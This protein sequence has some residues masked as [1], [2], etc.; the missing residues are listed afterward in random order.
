MF[1]KNN[2]M[3]KLWKNSKSFSTPFVSNEMEFVSKIG[4]NNIHELLFQMGKDPHA[5][6]DDK[7]RLYINGTRKKR[8]YEKKFLESVPKLCANLTVWLNNYFLEN[9]FLIF[10]NYSTS[11]SKK[12]SVLFANLAKPVIDLYPPGS[13][14]LETHLIIGRYQTTP[15]GVHVDD[16]NDR[17]IH[18]NLSNTPKHLHL[19]EIEKFFELTGSYEF[20]EHMDSIKKH[21]TTYTMQKGDAF[22]LPA[23]YYHV[24]ESPELSI[25]AAISLTKLSKGDIL[26]RVLTV[27]S[28]DIKAGFSTDKEPNNFEPNCAIDAL[29]K[30]PFLQENSLF[31]NVFRAAL[32][33]Y[34]ARVKS[35][36]YFVEKPQ[37]KTTLNL[38]AI[39]EEDMQFKKTSPFNIQFVE[40]D[41]RITL[42]S[43]GYQ[44]EC[45]AHHEV[46]RI[47]GKIR[48]TSEFYVS[49]L[50]KI[51]NNIRPKFV[52][53]IVNWLYCTGSLEVL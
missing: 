11:W 37:I 49:D 5:Y 6:H 14:S 45:N 35:N 43:R 20:I 27:V 7:I 23:S 36:M 40:N 10:V 46:L 47:I 8:F 39:L 18:F 16:P 19:W 25:V 41:G 29:R 4:L 38:D 48:E 42:Y 50:L 15:F 34:N 24:G 13:L 9:E 30:E 3:E 44:F 33:K 28:D 31:K 2:I 12:L 21:K 32:D 53:I 26:D 52:T 17:V 22:V 51:I 1:E